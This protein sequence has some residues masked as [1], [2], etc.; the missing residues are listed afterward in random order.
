LVTRVEPLLYVLTHIDT[1]GQRGN[2][3]LQ[4]AGT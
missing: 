4:V 3:T 1:H 2:Q